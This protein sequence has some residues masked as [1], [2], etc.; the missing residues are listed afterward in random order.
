MITA[1]VKA[2]I[3]ADMHQQLKSV[4]DVL[5]YQHAPLEP[6]CELYESFIDGDTFITLERWQDQESLD[7]HLEAEHVKQLVPELR[8]CVVNEEFHVTF[9]DSEDIQKITI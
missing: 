6:G 7:I 4:A 9:I 1:I 2:T 8:K 3:K 5:Q